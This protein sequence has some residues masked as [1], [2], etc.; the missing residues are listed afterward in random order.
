LTSIKLSIVAS[1]KRVDNFQAV[2][3]S[4]KTEL[5]FEVIFVGPLRPKEELPSNFHF[6]VSKVKPAQC[7]QIAINQALGEYVMII[8]DDLFFSQPYSID[9]LYALVCNSDNPFL[10]ASHR[11]SL[12]G[13]DQTGVMY[14]DAK[15]SQ[16]LLMPVAGLMRKDSIEAVGGIDRNFIGIMYD[17][18]LI[19][20]FYEQG[21]AVILGGEFVNENHTLRG[22]SFLCDDWWREDRQTLEKLWFFDKQY[23]PTRSRM[24]DGYS[25][26]GLNF[27]SQGPRG[28]W[29]GEGVAII[30]GCY[31]F[32]FRSRVV[33]RRYYK[34]VVGKL[35]R[36]IKTLIAH[37][38][39]IF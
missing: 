38:Q 2:Y 32:V 24:V 3:D 35:R 31:N 10:I 16:S 9:K 33:L 28:I 26:E 39:K 34:R 4:I 15:N 8:A 1:A 20:R 29:Q 37:I 36:I 5:S 12:N 27:K 17:V 22:N 21:G 23:K 7:V 19:L 11:Y 6:I 30:E 14:F 13:I 18:D 25:P